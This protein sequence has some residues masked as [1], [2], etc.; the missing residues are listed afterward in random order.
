MM[1]TKEGTEWR[2]GRFSGVQR[3][4]VASGRKVKKKG[5]LFLSKKKEERKGSSHSV[6]CG[7]SIMSPW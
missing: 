3:S 6:S 2:E 5:C 4:G 1:V 7:A